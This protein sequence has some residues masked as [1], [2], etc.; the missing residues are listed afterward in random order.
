MDSQFTV[1]RACWH[2]DL[3]NAAQGR[4]QKFAGGQNRGSGDGR[5]PAGS[6]S[7]GRAPVGVWGSKPPEAGDIYLMHNGLLTEKINKNIQH[8]EN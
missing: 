4:S 2:V 1:A 7:R 6:R 5:S 8:K 3:N